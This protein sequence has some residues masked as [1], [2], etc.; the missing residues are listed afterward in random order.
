M[1]LIDILKMGGVDKT[2]TRKL[3]RRQSRYDSMKEQGR[4]DCFE[5]Y[6]GY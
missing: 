6:E 5:F 3:V 4:N 2:Q 1:V